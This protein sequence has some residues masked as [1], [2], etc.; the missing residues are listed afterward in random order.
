MRGLALAAVGA[1]L[2]ATVSP[3]GAQPS[4][5]PPAEDLD[6]S[7]PVV[8]SLGLM[9]VMRTAEAVIWPKPFASMAPLDW[10]QGYGDAL[11]LPPRLDASAPWFEWDGD[12]WTI[13]VI[14]HGLFGSELYFR[15]RACRCNPA[16]ALLFASAATVTWEV[17]F[18]G[19]AVRPSA[20]DLWTTPIAGIALGELRY[21]GW[22]AAGSLQ[23][24]P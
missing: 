8:H 22:R 1:F 19:N 7:V 3:C 17:V 14:G 2:L 10:A 6:W 13:N 16:E 23:N 20:L 15:A 24:G 4:P 18:E 9:T 21:L 5:D 11:R 12:D